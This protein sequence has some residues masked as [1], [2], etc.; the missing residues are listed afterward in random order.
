MLS[1]LFLRFKSLY[2]T[3]PRQNRD[4]SS[5][6]NSTSSPLAHSLKRRLDHRL[7]NQFRVVTLTALIRQPRPGLLIQKQIVVTVATSP[8][9]MLHIVSTD[10]PSL[11]LS[12]KPKF[13]ILLVE[14]RTSPTQSLSP[15]FLEVTQRKG[16]GG[17]GQQ[18]N[19]QQWQQQYYYPTPVFHVREPR[20]ASTSITGLLLSEVGCG[21]VESA[22]GV[23]EG[24]ADRPRPR[25]L[26]TTAPLSFE[27]ESCFCRLHHQSWPTQSAANC[28]LNPNARSILP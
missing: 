24:L 22:A 3:T 16:G 23:F 1:T 11:R 10:A 15:L 26:H 13:A 7:Q 28:I 5:S 17:Q 14:A 4:T 9:L 8:Q 12:P 25:G 19:R 27:P 20:S 2:N 6:R 18:N 21:R